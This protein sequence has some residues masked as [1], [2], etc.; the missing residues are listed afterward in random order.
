MIAP[1]ELE[2]LVEGTGWRVARVVR[3]EG[4]RYV[5]VLEKGR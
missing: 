3:D 2:G 1:S 4:A 5:I